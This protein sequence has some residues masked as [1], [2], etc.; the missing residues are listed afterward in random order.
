MIIKK[1]NKESIPTMYEV[2]EEMSME[3]SNG[4]TVNVLQLSEIVSK[5]DIENKI[6][7]LT[8]QLSKQNEILSIINNL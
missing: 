3:T 2:Y 8:A 7:S 4:E 6:N 1:S 5:I